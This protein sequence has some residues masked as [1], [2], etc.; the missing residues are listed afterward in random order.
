MHKARMCGAPSEGGGA[1]FVERLQLLGLARRIG[2]P[3]SRS[4]VVW[5]GQIHEPHLSLI[6]NP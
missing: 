2:A 1:G 5:H 6:S 3:H 4:A